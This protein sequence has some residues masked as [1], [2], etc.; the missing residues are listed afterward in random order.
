MIHLLQLCFLLLY[1][2]SLL[3]DSYDKVASYLLDIKYHKNIPKQL[4]TNVS[5][6][7]PFSDFQL[8]HALTQVLDIKQFKEMVIN[9]MKKKIKKKT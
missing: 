9:F 2:L 1:G 4:S 3:A 7:W 6:K 5:A 8:Q